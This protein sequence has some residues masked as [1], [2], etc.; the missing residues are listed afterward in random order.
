MVEQPIQAT[1]N[2]TKHKGHDVESLFVYVV[3]FALLRVRYDLQCST[4]GYLEFVS[5]IYDIIFDQS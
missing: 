4:Q 2:T 5:D 1:M 3:I